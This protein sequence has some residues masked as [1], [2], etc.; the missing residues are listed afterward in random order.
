MKYDFLV[1]GA[2]ISGLTF[3]RSAADKGRKVLVVEKKAFPGGLLH[4]RMEGPIEVHEY[5]PHIFHTSER[6][7]WDFFRRF[8]ELDGFVN[9]PVAMTAR[10]IV[11]LPFTMYTF[12]QLWGT[13][14]PDE[15]LKKLEEQRQH[16]DREPLNIKEK[17]LAEVGSDIYYLLIEGYT[18]KHW[19]RSCDELPPWII[20]RLP[21]RLTYDCRYF[22]DRW[23]GLPADGWNAFIEAIVDHP[24]MTILYGVDFFEHRSELEVQAETIICTAPVDQWHDWCEG[25]LEW[26]T[27]EFKEEIHAC[28]SVQGAPVINW[29]SRSVQWTRTSEWKHFRN[30]KCDFTIVTKEHPMKWIS[31]MEPLYPIP[32]ARNKEMLAAYSIRTINE[33]N[34]HFLG[35]QG[36]YKYLNIDKAILESLDLAERLL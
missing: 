33:L 30:V 21:A 7:V 25:M 13:K 8:A 20:G 31:G 12:N 10:G 5:G 16:L 34:V 17:A 3:A 36:R 28:E 24:N 9:S 27:L 18:E 14:T 19:G 26:R 2:G 11:S 29:P 1:V 23:Q 22:S 15:A 32:S 4:C 35:R 6:R